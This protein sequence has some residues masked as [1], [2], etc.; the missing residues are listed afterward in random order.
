MGAGHR[1]TASPQMFERAIEKKRC[2][3]SADRCGLG[4]EFLGSFGNVGVR[5]D[6][7]STRPMGERGGWRFT[8][9]VEVMVGSETV[10]TTGAASSHESGWGFSVAQ[11]SN[12]TDSTR[13]KCF[14]KAS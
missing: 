12:S 13:V 1:G 11:R 14:V 2:L 10:V 6:M 5:W 9:E 7:R 4:A 8:T 3:L